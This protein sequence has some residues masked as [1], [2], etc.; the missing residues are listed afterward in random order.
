[1]FSC[2]ECGAF[3]R[4]ELSNDALAG[5]AGIVGAGPL[6]GCRATELQNTIYYYHQLLLHTT[7]GIFCYFFY[8]LLLSTTKTIA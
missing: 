4:W 5:I 3:G 6:R 7:E 8:S 2:L 1:M